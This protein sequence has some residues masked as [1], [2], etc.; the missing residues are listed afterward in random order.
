MFMFDRKAFFV[1]N[2]GSIDEDK[3][4]SDALEAGAE[5]VM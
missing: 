3:L 1:A 5:D 2:D 4:I